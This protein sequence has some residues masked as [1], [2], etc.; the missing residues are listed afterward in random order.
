VLR[1]SVGL[2]LVTQNSAPVLRAAFEENVELSI[3]EGAERLWCSEMMICLNDIVPD[4]AAKVQSL[5]HS[6]SFSQIEGL[7]VQSILGTWGSRW[8]TCWQDLPDNP[9]VAESEH[10]SYATYDTWMS[11][12][13]SQLAPYVHHGCCINPEHLADLI[14]LRLAAHWLN[15][16][17]GRWVNG[18]TQRSRRYCRKCMAFEVEDEKHFLMA[19]PAYQAI[20]AECQELYD[21][22]GDDMRKLMCHPRQHI[23]A[24]FAMAHHEM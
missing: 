19:C 24:N 2:L 14:R 18:G 9:R 11:E 6:G 13:I 22:C 5:V 1:L 10:V 7:G 8:I 3:K 21:D 4:Y 20:R 23:L 15:V 16:V 17:A 12:C